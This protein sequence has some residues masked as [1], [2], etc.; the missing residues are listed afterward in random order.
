LICFSFNNQAR[1]N[2]KQEYN[3]AFGR[4]R[5][6]FNNKIRSN[7]VNFTTTIKNK[8]IKFISNDYINVDLKKLTKDDFVYCDPP[9]LI[10]SCNYN[11]G[12]R[13]FKGWNETE[14]YRLLNLLDN[15]HSRGIKFGL[16]NVLENKGK[17]NDI[18][19]EWSKQYNVNYLNNTYGNCNHQTKDKSKD[20]TIEVL[21]TN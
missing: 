5:S 20:T 1:F 17:S 10:T 18:L 7:L 9:Y 14:E 13:G 19:K 3:Q 4:N 12:K 6:D 8:N 15:L 2:N 21:I 16:S 11:D